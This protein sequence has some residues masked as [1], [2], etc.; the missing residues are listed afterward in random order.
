MLI[1]IMYVCMG[2]AQTTVIELSSYDKH[3][4]PGFQKFKEPTVSVVTKDSEHRVTNVVTDR[5]DITYL[6]NGKTKEEVTA[7]SKGASVTTDAATGATVE[8][9]FGDVIFSK[10]GTVTIQVIATP[11][12]GWAAQYP[13]APF[14]TTYSVV[15][16]PLTA[17]L[18]FSP[19]F[20]KVAETDDALTFHATAAQAPYSSQYM[21]NEQKTSLPSYKIAY[22]NSG[23]VVSDITDRFDVNIS[24]APEGG[25]DKVAYSA[26]TL[27]FAGSGATRYDTESDAIDAAIAMA[28]K[29]GT[30]TYTFTPK[31]DYTGIYETMT[32]TV[33]IMVTASQDKQRLKLFLNR[34]IVLEENVTTDADG[35]CTLHVYKY[36]LGDPNV[37]HNYQYFT[38][39]PV[40]MTEDGVTVPVQATRG[41]GAWGD[42]TYLYEV[43]DGDDANPGNMIDPADGATVLGSYYDNCRYS[44]FWNNEADVAFPAGMKALGLISEDKF[45]VAKPGLVKVAVYASL[46]TE[47]WQSAGLKALYEP[48][49]DTNGDPIIKKDQYGSDRYVYT[50]PVYFYIDVM[51][52]VP[53]LLFDPDPSTMTF[54]KGDKI[55]MR[56]RFLVSG[57]IDDNSDGIEGWLLW[58]ANTGENTEFDATIGH[59]VDH[60]AYT[61]F[62]SERNKENITI[63]DWPYMNGKD[64]WDTNGG[65]GYSY[66]DYQT[67]AAGSKMIGHDII[68]GDKVLVG[69][70]L[71]E[72][73]ADNI[74][75]KKASHPTLQAGDKEKGITYYSTRGYGEAFEKWTMEFT[76]V[77]TYDITYTIHPYNHTR[78]DVGT[79][80]A[81]TVT[82]TY[83]VVETVPTK[84]DLSYTY[85][86]VP[87]C[88][89]WDFTEPVAKVVVPS[90]NNYDVTRYFDLSYEI[91]DDYNKGG[92]KDVV[93]LDDTD[94]SGHIGNFSVYYLVTERNEDYG[95]TIK[96][97]EPILAINKATGDVYV[98]CAWTGNVVIKVS[99]EKKEED[100]TQ[101][102]DDPD[103]TYYTIRI[104]D[105][106]G[107]AKYEIIAGCKT[108]PCS[109]NTTNP[110]FDATQIVGE[111]GRFHFIGVG[112][113]YG[114]T[115]YRGVP[116][117]DMTLG[118][119]P[120]LTTDV[121]NWIAEATTMD[122]K[123]CCSHESNDHKPVAVQAD[124]V[125]IDE[126]GIPTGGTFYKFN[127]TTNGYLSIDA[128]WK[129]GEIAYLVSKNSKTGEIL[130][131]EILVTSA[132]AK[133]GDLTFAKA[134]I[135]G[136]TYYLYNRTAGFLRL[137]GFTYQPAFVFDRNTTIAQSTH[138]IEAT[139]FMNGLSSGIPTI[140]SS[141]NDRVTFSIAA[142]DDQYM[143]VGVHNGVV[144]PKKMTVQSNGS[145]SYVTV[146]ATV[147]S[148]DETLGDCVNKT[149]TY[150]LRII[151]IP[152]YVVGQYSTVEADDKYH[153]VTMQTKVTTTNI[154]TAITMTFGGWLR[155]YEGDEKYTSAK[156]EPISDSWTNKSGLIGVK[157]V[158]K[159]A[160][161]T[162][163]DAYK[164]QYSSY[165]IDATHA[166]PASRVGSELADYD[167]YYNKPI[168][169]FNF[170]T[171]AAQ[172]PI[173]E[174]GFGPLQPSAGNVYKYASGASEE[175]IY[176]ENNLPVYNTTYRLP[177]KGAY[178]KFEPEESGIVMV[179][180]VQ[181]GSVDYHSGIASDQI[182]TTKNTYNEV[183]WRPLYITDETGKTVEMVNSFGT[184][185]QYMTNYEDAANTGSFTLGIS[186]CN[187]IEPAVEGSFVV[188]EDCVMEPGCS[189]DF[190]QFRGTPADRKR[191]IAAW[192]RK[193]ERESII[194]LDDGGFALA[195]KAYVRYAFR[196]KSGKSYF[197]FQPGSKF[198]FGGFSFVPDGY[199]ENSK[200]G[201]NWSDKPEN[202]KDD[203]CMSWHGIA[204]AQ[205]KETSQ[206]I[207]WGSFSS[208][209][210]CNVT[211]MD[212]ASG[213]SK[214]RTIQSGSW[215]GICLPF[216]VSEK[217]CK[218]LFGED[219][220]LLTCAGVDAI[221]QIH[222]ERH[223][224]QYI[225][226]DRP[227]LLLPQT[228]SATFHNVT[229]EGTSPSRFNVSAQEYLFK[230][231]YDT[232]TMP[233]GSVVAGST[234]SK[235]GLFSFTADYPIGG[236]R[237]YFYLDPSALQT[238][239]KMFAITDFT[240]M[241]ADDDETENIAT[242]IAYFS[243]DGGV[244][245]LP[246]NTAVYNVAGQKMGDGVDALNNLKKGVY[247]V[248]GKKFLVK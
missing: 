96:T 219:Y 232:E 109:P 149:A 133:Q 68:V 12:S 52:R 60:F 28:G 162:V 11:K 227:Y 81:G 137:H 161:G 151:D 185:E 91:P 100:K 207:Y 51:K 197:V 239:A 97:K 192:P 178:V 193:G 124:A 154:P 215:T 90:Q 142:A 213:G 131:D 170:F 85:T 3:V 199:P 73:T 20:S 135:A 22:T 117:I 169:G 37:N 179:Y 141:N 216:S 105:P 160:D 223:A 163:Y 58:G 187:P 4:A 224:H 42:F 220:S 118:A 89:G 16:D 18:T 139:T 82:Y 164:E 230:G 84:I 233:K 38:P 2:M 208:A 191:L 218:E 23:G 147:D 148:P 235:N 27:T 34:D 204:N 62:I 171:A 130:S 217:Q 87:K 61:F 238:P 30:L 78:W 43:L 86:T 177:C 106:T 175:V 39:N 66:I 143:S 241:G 31:A 121:A 8:Y 110:R 115:V 211:L 79:G 126:D 1:S 32:E 122:V 225:E 88:N 202:A 236:Y 41:T 56:S 246:E 127:P 119:E 155:D 212:C 98:G 181:N 63:H 6:I 69:D 152:S 67:V 247:M 57:H 107:L 7:N 53:E 176:D 25:N 129:E 26:N 229:V 245:M 44:P 136:E 244:Q 188:D 50:E 19:S 206:T 17:Q 166:A 158:D 59:E 180:L 64:N 111:Y 9:L 116:G 77:G 214:G 45:Q 71:V 80:D 146:T 150:K 228:G 165:I 65:D 108:D 205:N 172:N 168:D 54:V 242:G 14:T 21:V 198:E 183:R 33:D 95:H 5:F 184:A 46:S 138:P 196:V 209:E 190:R 40:L 221:G 234:G 48:L 83:E 13:S 203:D 113:L 10:A 70:E 24:Y 222:F 104:I 201:L 74:D 120:V 99:G 72:V 75:E 128:N 35:V 210:N 47:E 134:L 173:D 92:G 94:F 36:G 182:K 76:K 240:V 243:A 153:D 15:V 167:P 189:F 114:G 156:G 157:S 194:R 174:R 248:N 29:T 145:I 103:P 186:R 125:T 195:H 231:V 237:A 140:V 101:P 144:T 49:K 200:Y 102:Y 123:Y 112:E 132:T 226:A 55:D 93:V 159:D